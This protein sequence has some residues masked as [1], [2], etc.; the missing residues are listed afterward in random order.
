[1]SRNR[2]WSSKIGKGRQ[3]IPP[4]SNACQE[5]LSNHLIYDLPSARISR[6]QEGSVLGE[7]TLKF[8]IST[9]CL[10]RT[11]IYHLLLCHLQNPCN[12]RANTFNTKE[13][14]NR[15]H[16]DVGNQ[17]GKFWQVAFTVEGANE[18]F[19]GRRTH[20]FQILQV[21]RKERKYRLIQNAQTPERKYLERAH[22]PL[23]P[24]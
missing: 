18:T 23:L 20:F 11:A 16:L 2:R 12:S 19:K 22:I 10:P 6:L 3:E 7:I 24:C 21:L 4:Y 8:K 5:D 17:S 14:A 13:S 9:R 1:M 15:Q